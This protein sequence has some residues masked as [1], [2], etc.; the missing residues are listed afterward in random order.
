MKFCRFLESAAHDVPGS[1]TDIYSAYKSLKKRL[2]RLPVASAGDPDFLEAERGFVEETS[3]EIDALSATRVRRQAQSSQQLAQLQARMEAEG[4][5]FEE[6]HALYQSLV[7]FHGETLLLMHW[8]ILAYTAIVKLLKKHQKHTG[9]LVQA[10]HLRTVLSQ[11]SWSTEVLARLIEQAAVC[12]AQLQAELFKNSASSG[13]SP[14]EPSPHRP[15]DS[16]VLRDTLATLAREAGEEATSMEGSTSSHTMGGGEDSGGEEPNS[17]LTLMRAE[18]ATSRPTTT[19]AQGQRA[20]S[21]PV[22]N[23][24]LLH[25]MQS[26]LDNWEFLRQNASTPSTVLPGATPP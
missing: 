10:P 3:R 4:E 24:L 18:S 8:S 15:I 7:N 22:V 11:S 17:S 25:Q 21:D 1:Y 6:R 5:S 23:T 9:I 14:E 16:E 26:A 12:I 20:P 13:P 2:K 19:A